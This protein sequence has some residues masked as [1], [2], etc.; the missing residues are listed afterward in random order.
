[1]TERNRWS[2]SARWLEGGLLLLGL[3]LVG[4]WLVSSIET[5][6]FQTT[7]SRKLDAAVRQEKSSGP[8]TPGAAKSPAAQV[9]AKSAAASVTAK[10]AAVPG[11]ARAAKGVLGRI[12][13]PRLRISGMI[14]EG[15]D[16][17]TLKRAVGHV[18]STAQP[19]EVGNVGLAAHRDGLFRGLGGVR[20]NDL[21]RIVTIRGTYTYRVEWM[22]V[23]EP[24]RVDVLDSTAE[25]SITLITCYPFDFIGHAPKRFV[26]RARQFDS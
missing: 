8:P 11:S 13:I 24:H 9:S 1:M 15:T 25:P 12:E 19:G 23:V 5:R 4:V 14:A 3:V 6:A 22:A 20:K 2:T 21:V 7:E 17:G 10:S 18:V 26:V 16:K